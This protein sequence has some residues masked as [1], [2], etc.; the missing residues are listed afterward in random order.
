[1]SEQDASDTSTVGQD[2]IG[3]PSKWALYPAS[4]PPS[5]SM[6]RKHAS[7]AY[8]SQLQSPST[9][10]SEQEGAKSYSK[11]LMSDRIIQ[12][13][14][15]LVLLW[16]IAGLAFISFENNSRYASN[17]HLYNASLQTAPNNSRLHYNM[18][19][20]F[21]ALGESE[22][23]LMHY[24]RATI[25]RPDDHMAFNNL[26]VQLQQLGFYDEAESVIRHTVLVN[27]KYAEAWYNMATIIN[28]KL[29]Q[30]NTTFTQEELDKY[31]ADVEQAYRRCI[32]LDPMHIEASLNLG[33][34]LDSDFRF[35]EAADVYRNALKYAPK[36]PALLSNFGVLYQNWNRLDEA[37]DFFK[38]AVQADEKFIDVSLALCHRQVFLDGLN[39]FSSSIFLCFF[40]L[41]PRPSQRLQNARYV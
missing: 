34:F 14:G 33:V 16:Y 32:A 7:A 22:K 9:P 15:F 2:D 13:I 23:A 37:E 6:L 28:Y 3:S 1:M 8:H 21:T 27:E 11:S 19:T 26:A 30:N 41:L 24:H 17:Y 4:A 10:T 25:H 36:H 29:L 40:V 18:G 39:L 38:A 20:I 35:S 12:V 5:P 31:R